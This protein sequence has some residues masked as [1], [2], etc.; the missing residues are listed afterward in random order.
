MSYSDK[1]RILLFGNN[2][3]IIDDFFLSLQTDYELM[4]SSLRLDD[5][6]I[7][8]NYF[9]P[10]VLI[11]CMEE[12]Y[13]PDIKRVAKLF[14]D[15]YKR[16]LITCA[17][18]SPNE[19]DSLKMYC[20]RYLDL[21]LQ[22]DFN[23]KNIKNSLT[24]QFNN[25]ELKMYNDVADDTDSE[26]DDLIQRKLDDSADFGNLENTTDPLYSDPNLMGMK[27]VLVI[28][29]DPSVLKTIKGHLEESYAVSTAPS[30]AVARK[31]LKSRHVDLIL[32]DYMMPYEDGATF[33]KYLK[34]L[35]KT[36]NIPVVFLTGVN[37]SEKIMEVLSLKPN[38]YLLKPVDHSTL[39]SKVYDLIGH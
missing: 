35:N 23:S 11:Y 31:F 6:H 19:I 25:K 26:I 21:H 14:K 12:E 30:A 7:H 4:S 10:D 20:D 33:F 15:M 38:G 9:E 18:S 37:D 5:I 34:A 29:D 3:V 36:K 16:G 13:E 22:G 1:K 24:E 28:D 39:T 17:Y 8:L 27:R 32:L 2:A